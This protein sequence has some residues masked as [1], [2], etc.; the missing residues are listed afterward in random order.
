MLINLLGLARAPCAPST[1]GPGAR[2][3][4]WL[5]LFLVCYAVSPLLTWDGPYCLLLGLSMMLTTVGLWSRNLRLTGCSSLLNSPP[6]FLYNLIAGAWS[7]AAIEMVAFWLL[8]PG[9]LAV[10]PAPRRRAER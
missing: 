2:S 5:V 6:M 10:R 9:R 3:R 1:T 7:G 8:R 4:V